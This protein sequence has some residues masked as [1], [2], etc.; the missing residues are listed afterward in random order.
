M[1]L[2][3]EDS[4]R[5]NVLLVNAVATRIDEGALKVHGL[6]KDGSETQMLLNPNCNVDQYVKQV[7]ELF[8]STV[9]GSPGGYPVFLKRWTRMGQ[10]SDARLDELLMLGEPEAVVAVT[11]ASA[12]TDDIAEKAWWAMPDAANA[13]RMLKN[14]EVVNGKMGSILAEFLVEF[15][16][17]E[18]N[19]QAIIESVALVLQDNIIDQE[20]QQKLWKKGTQKNIFRLGF[21]KTIPDNLPDKTCIRSDREHHLV[22]QSELFRLS[23]CGN[24][25][26]CM[27]S[28]LYGEQGQSYLAGCEFVMKKPAS[29]EAVVSLLDTVAHYF[30]AVQVL[31]RCYADMDSLL[32]DVAKFVVSNQDQDLYQLLQAL[33][34]VKQDIHSMLVLAHAGIPVINPIFAITDAIGSLMRKK[35]ESVAIPINHCLKTLQ[36][37]V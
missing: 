1:S 22:E 23:E 37:T 7:R 18:E 34:E 10:T 12:L 13:R 14:P 32:A 36:G 3:N 4:L 15:L 17:F 33:P 25:F 28:K 27:L 5:L 11:C 31:D 21:L 2:S 30:Q 6:L 20:T 9:L 16:P 29:Q 35:I 8:S 26:A 19:P 24:R